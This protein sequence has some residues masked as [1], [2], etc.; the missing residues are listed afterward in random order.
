MPAHRFFS[1][2]WL[3][4]AVL[5][6]GFARPAA[7]RS[8]GDSLLVVADSILLRELTVTALQPVSMRGDTLVY[9]LRAFPVPEGSRLGE[10]LRRLPGVDVGAD[11]AVRAQ[12]I[13]VT[14]LLLNGREF[15]SANRSVVL[16]NLPADALLDVKVYERVVENDEDMGLRA[17][18]ERVMDL[19]TL[20]GKEKGW[21]TDLTGAAGYRDRYSG[22]ASASHFDEVWQNMISVSSDNLPQDFGIGESFYEKVDRQQQDGDA[23][24]HT[25]SIM[26]SRKKDAWETTGSAYYT[27]SRNTRGIESLTE[28]LLSTGQLYSR[29]STDGED[30]THNVT[31]NFHIE[32]RDSMTTVTIDP[33]LMYTK[34]NSHTDYI[35]ATSNRPLQDVLEWTTGTASPFLLNRQRV[36]SISNQQAWNASVNAHLRRRLSRH[37][38]AFTIDAAWELND[39]S[40]FQSTASSTDYFRRD[41]YDSQLRYSDAPDRDEQVRVRMAW[42]EPLGRYLK[43]KAEWGMSNRHE[44][45]RQ[46]VFTEGATHPID[47]LSKDATY[48]FLNRDARLMLQWMPSDKMVLSIGGL[49]NPVRTRTRYIRNTLNIDTL[50]Y[51][52]NW[53]PE[54][55][56]YYRSDNGWNASLKYTGMSRQPGL[57]D[58]LPIVDD[59][60]PLH[61]R[62][63][64]PGLKPSFVH[65]LSGTY[66]WFDADTQTQLNL[67]VQGQVEQNAITDVVE[68]DATDGVRRTS[69]DNVDGCRQIAATWTAASGFEPEAKWFFDFQGDVN[70]TRRVGLQER[71]LM[72]TAFAGDQVQE[73]T[74]TT[75]QSLI[76]QYVALQWQP[77]I[78]SVKPYG[79]FTYNGL[80]AQDI[81]VTPADLWLVGVGLVGRLETNNGW[82]IAVDA[83]RQSR[84]G[85]V[86]AVDND[87]E[88]LIDLEMAYA[89][90]KGRAAEVRLQACDL[91]RQRNLSRSVT[92]AT[93]RIEAS[94]PH[95]VT[96][97]LLLS[98][99]YRFTLMGK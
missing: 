15:F 24:H 19:T 22:N 21:L 14:Y 30:R 59:T 63:G 37:G 20:P 31:G 32:R 6:M 33:Q 53:A 41:Q 43:L 87:D 49:Y 85:Y 48:D 17:R 36:H 29:T 99:T 45:F 51:V 60:D 98:F 61:L 92:S 23:R 88:W 65:Q 54:L 96:H 81:N 7:A 38:R 83:S 35:S 56:F 26:T 57:L 10:L 84:R 79:F 11:G 71:H 42:I 9:D 25:L 5:L 44:N 40:T 66:F 46:P 73:M 16:E 82:S 72:E 90:L 69:V 2:K 34:G 28:N 89:F 77:G 27:A 13:P 70:M 80:R 95:S 8:D 93:T 62:K 68:I 78:F 47:S 39:V 64:N 86:E 67:Q 75:N 4:I 76:R 18:T 58:L 74:F 55:N 3:W 12:G 91:L 52:D 97:Y 1:L 94:Y 50:R